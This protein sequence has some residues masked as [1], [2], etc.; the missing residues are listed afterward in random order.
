MFTGIISSKAKIKQAPLFGEAGKLEIGVE[1][2][3]LKDSKQGDSIAVDGVCLTIINLDNDSFTVE[4]SPETVD[5]TNFNKI[6][7]GRIVNLEH[8]VKLGDSLDG[9]L[10]Q[11]HVDTVVKVVN[12]NKIAD[13]KKIVLELPNIK[14]IKYIAE[15]GSIT[16]NGVSLTVNQVCNTKFAVNIIPYTL[17]ATNLDSLKIGDNVNLE[18]DMF[19]RYCVNYL[20]KS[21]IAAEI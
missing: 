9:H 14:Y 17:S 19:A 4:I 16:L 2:R 5:K 1:A 11:G 10:V 8:A 12:I 21:K 7:I 13:N 20:E 18:I 15:K 3:F 6:A